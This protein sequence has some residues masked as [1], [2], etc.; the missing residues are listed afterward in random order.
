MRARACCRSASLSSSRSSSP[1]M[2]R[3]SPATRTEIRSPK[4]GCGSSLSPASTASHQAAIRDPPPC[5]ARV[6]LRLIPEPERLR[7]ADRPSRVSYLDADATPRA[8]TDPAGEPRP[9]ALPDDSRSAPLP[10]G[11]PLRDA[12]VR[13]RRG[14]WLGGRRRRD[15]LAWRV[16]RPAGRAGHGD[17]VVGH[18]AS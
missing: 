12:A 8:A 16:S 9:P 2:T 15:G 14:A 5:R 11:R 18:S 17:R 3:R 1:E 10:R 7:N 6:V 4:I 13:P